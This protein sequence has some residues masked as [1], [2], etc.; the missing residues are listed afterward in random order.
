MFGSGA[1]AAL[2]F[3]ALFS[4]VIGIVIVGQTLYSI[5]REHL[6]ELATLKAMGASRGELV[7]FVSWQASFLALVGG[8]SA[9]SWRSRCKACSRA[10]ASPWR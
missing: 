9:W 6:K 4:L 1:G 7:G 10:R 8:A 3:S 2:A 5:T